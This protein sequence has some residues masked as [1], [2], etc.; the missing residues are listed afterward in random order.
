MGSPTAVTVK[1]NRWP[2]LA[3]AEAAL[4][5]AG[6]CRPDGAGVVVGGAVLVG[7]AVVTVVAGPEMG[8]GKMG[9]GATGA[10]A[11]VTTRLSRRSRR[12]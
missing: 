7:G 2:T 5:K 8:A 10:E 9:V 3:V 12:R 11:T 1:E 4:L 6:A